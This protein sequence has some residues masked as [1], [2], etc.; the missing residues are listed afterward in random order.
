MVDSRIFSKKYMKSKFMVN[1]GG[2]GEGVVHLHI[3]YIDMC[4]YE[5]YGF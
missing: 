2:G 1:S 3:T 4:P 5:G